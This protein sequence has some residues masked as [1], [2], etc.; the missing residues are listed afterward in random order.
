MTPRYEEWRQRHQKSDAAIRRFVR[1]KL[2]IKPT[3]QSEF[4]TRC[5]DEWTVGF[6]AAC[7]G[8]QDSQPETPKPASVPAEVIETLDLEESP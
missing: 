6:L 8:W 7:L 3:N 4:A 5:V 2:G 1:Q